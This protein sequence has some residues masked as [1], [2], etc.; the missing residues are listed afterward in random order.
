[1]TFLSEYINIECNIRVYY[2]DT[3]SGG[4]VYHGAYL[5]FLERARTEWFRNIGLSHTDF[6]DKNNTLFV[7]RKA[8][9]RFI[10]PAKL[11]NLL[12]V[13]CYPV[14]I[15]K[16]QI[17]FKQEIFTRGMKIMQSSINLG[18]LDSIYFKPKLIPEILLKKLNC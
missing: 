8:N 7:V 10:K 5:N 13:T 9:L 15:K 3:D 4:V 18:C 14:E 11:D 1:M 2:Q 17:L 16:L 6:F 12:K